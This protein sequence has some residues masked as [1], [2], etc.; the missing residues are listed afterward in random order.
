MRLTHIV[1]LPC[2]QSPLK[3]VQPLASASARLSWLRQG[4]SGESWARV[5]SWE[6]D[7]KGVSYSVDT[8]AFWKKKFPEAAL[9][10]IMGSDQWKALPQWKDFQ[11]L[12]RWVHFLVFPR[13]ETPK[14]RRGVSMS[15]LP[16]RL[17][18]SSTEIRA[19]IKRGLSIRGMVPPE[20]MSSVG[21]SRYYQ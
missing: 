14:A 16:L 18:L 12:A 10:W 9:F 1:Y 13:P 20:I 15:V 7:R 11:K 8:A 21:Q 17:D 4:L 5:S 3:K 6:I 19:R 2:A